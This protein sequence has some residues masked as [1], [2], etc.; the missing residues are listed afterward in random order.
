MFGFDFT[1]RHV[2]KVKIEKADVLSRRLDVTTFSL[3]QVITKTK[4]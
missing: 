2:P 1:L 3:A 4:T